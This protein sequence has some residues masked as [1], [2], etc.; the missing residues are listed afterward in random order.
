LSRDLE[1][2]YSQDVPSLLN[3]LK[4]FY[5]FNE[6][7]GDILEDYE[8]NDFSKLYDISNVHP[9]FASNDNYVFWL[10]DTAGAIYMW[11]RVNST[12]SY[13][14]HDLREASFGK[15]PFPPR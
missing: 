7:S 12:M 6:T 10:E 11:S 2:Q 8:I 5:P 14:G 1:A 9:I 3:I 4:S 15:L 13:L